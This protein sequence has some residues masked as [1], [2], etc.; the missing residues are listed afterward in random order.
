[1]AL[2]G[3]VGA[4]EARAFGDAV[5]R[6][7]CYDMAA[8]HHH[9]RVGVGGLLL[10]DGTDEDGVE[11][12]GRWEWDFDLFTVSCCSFPMSWSRA[13]WTYR[14]LILRRPLCTRLLHDVLQLQQMRQ[15]DGS[16]GRRNV[17]RRICRETEQ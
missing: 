12:I 15:C 8:G 13:T 5:K 10:G 1:M 2:H 16:S 11:V 14:K 7:L 4:L 3:T 17:Q 6:F 9:G